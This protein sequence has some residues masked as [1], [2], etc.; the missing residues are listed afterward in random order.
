MTTYEESSWPEFGVEHIW[1]NATVQDTV[2]THRG[3]LVEMVHR[4]QWGVACYM[5]NAIQS[6]E[7]DEYLYHEALVHPV[8]TTAMAST[9]T[10]AMAA[11][12]TTV[13]TMT[14]VPPTRVMIIGGGEG[15]TAREVLKWPVAHVDM[16]EWDNDVVRLFKQKY[17]QWAAGAWEDPRLSIHD[18]DIFEVIGTPPSQ[19]YDVIIIDLVDPSEENRPL[20]E[21]LLSRIG[22]WLAPHGSMALYAGIRNI[23]APMQP[24]QLLQSMLPAAL[25]ASVIPYKVFIPSF[26]GESLFLLLNSREPILFPPSIPMKLTQKI[27]DSYQVFDW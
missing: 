17:P 10:T 14:T 26:S 16:F 13:T 1:H 4:P 15:A 6:C 3:T 12:M 20:W 11:T 7:V 21:L 23:L 27:W 22:T 19:P 2:L 8:M 9:M 5:D 18:D 24:H 25:C